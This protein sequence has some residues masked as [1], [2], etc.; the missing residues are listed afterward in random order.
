[1]N[2]FGILQMKST[3]VVTDPEKSVDPLMEDE[4]PGGNYLDPLAEM[5]KHTFLSMESLHSYL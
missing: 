5:R 4:D 1:M 3:S 2:N